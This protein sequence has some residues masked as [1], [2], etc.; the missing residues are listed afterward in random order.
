MR[1]SRRSRLFLV[2]GNGV[3]D[4]LSSVA[5]GLLSGGEDALALV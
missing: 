1:G 3:L 2:T 5:E 4:G